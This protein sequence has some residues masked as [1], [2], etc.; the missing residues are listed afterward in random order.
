M[1]KIRDKT[2]EIIS[3]DSTKIA[4]W[5][6]LVDGIKKK[7]WSICNELTEGVLLILLLLKYRFIEL[8]SITENDKEVIPKV[9]SSNYLPK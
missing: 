3:K 4:M 1:D 9:G 7:N 6:I 2:R 5:L 8:S